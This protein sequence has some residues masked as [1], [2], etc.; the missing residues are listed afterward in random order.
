MLSNLRMILVTPWKCL[1]CSGDIWKSFQVF[2]WSA[3]MFG[4]RLVVSGQFRRASGELR[5]RYKYLGWCSVLIVSPR[6]NFG[7]RRNLQWCCTF[8]SGVTLQALHLR[9]F[10]HNRL[11]SSSSKPSNSRLFKR[12]DYTSQSHD[13]NLK[14]AIPSWLVYLAASDRRTECSWFQLRIFWG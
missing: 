6:T 10:S 9:I 7:N 13:S 12:N 1:K 5:Q 8:C 2:G 3:K 4:N 11:H 14:A